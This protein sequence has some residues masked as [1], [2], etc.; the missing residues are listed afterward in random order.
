MSFQY[1]SVITGRPLVLSA[2]TAATAYLYFGFA[3]LLT[4]LGVYFGT[5]YAPVIFSTGMNLFLVIASLAI[6][7]SAGYWAEHAPLN[8]ILG[9]AFPVI[10]GLTIAPLI[11]GIMLGYENGPAILFNALVATACMGASAAVFV[12]VSGRDLRGMG[13]VLVMGLFGL[14]GFSLLQMFVP[15]LRTGMFEMVI[16]CFGIV[17]FA[18][19]TA[20]DIQRIE[21]QGRLGANPFLL[22]LSLYLDIFNLFLY[23]LRLMMALSGERR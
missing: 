3:L 5:I 7:F 10:S 17:L 21:Q 4:A 6:V 9:I 2:S 18:A 23:I 11:S 14:I 19:F 8:V 20:Y 12:R 22:A 15:A 16:S 13:G 1:G